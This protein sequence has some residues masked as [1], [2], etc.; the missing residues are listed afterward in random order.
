[1]RVFEKCHQGVAREEGEGLKIKWKLPEVN[2]RVVSRGQKELIDKFKKV[3]GDVISIWV[4]VM[5]N[6]YIPT[7][8]KFNYIIINTV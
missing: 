6:T 5:E 1:M 7:E 2:T 4:Q 8:S 3:A